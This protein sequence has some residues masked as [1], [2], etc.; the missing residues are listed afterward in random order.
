MEKE[1]E[2][3]KNESNSKFSL[4][5]KKYSD[6]INELE[7]TIKNLRKNNMKNKSQKNIQD[8]K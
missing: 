2:K 4:I 7:S 3:L 1:F 5:N 6:T 8:K